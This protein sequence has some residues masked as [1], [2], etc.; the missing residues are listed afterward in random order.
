M[1]S[2][3]TRRAA[4]ILLLL[5]SL[6]L[7]AACETTGGVADEG[8]PVFVEEASAP[9]EAPGTPVAKGGEEGEVPLAVAESEQ[10]ADVPPGKELEEVIVEAQRERHEVILD[11]VSEAK[12]ILRN[13]ELEYV[14]TG[15]GRKEALRGRPVVFALWS[16]AKQEWTIAHI[17][18]PRPPVKW[19][20]GRKPFPFIMRTPGV[21]ARHVKGT[22]MH[23]D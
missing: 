7:T 8:E 23:R 9:Q 13:V 11:L 19:K 6:I 14:F 20:P 10:P 21:E 1:N 3:P 16:E 18:I 22:G 4:Q 5:A 12:S 2:L 15:K 17:E